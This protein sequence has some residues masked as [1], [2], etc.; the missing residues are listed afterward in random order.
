[1]RPARVAVGALLASLVPAC[2]GAPPRPPAAFVAPGF[3]S[4]QLATERL[5]VL[6]LGRLGLPEGGPRDL[7]RDSLEAALARLVEE[8]LATAVAETGVVGRTVGP[9]VI[10]PVLAGTA[11]A[12]RGRAY[13]ALDRATLTGV[14]ALDDAPADDLRSLGR[15]IGA[16]FLLVPHALDLAPADLFRFEA[17]LAVDLV[18]A[19]AGRVVWRETVRAES[20]GAPSGAAPD[21][22]VAALEGAVRAAA[23]RTATRLSRLGQDDAESAAVAP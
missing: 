10:A 1:M 22:Y 8:T 23:V 21:L 15:A 19:D 17:L 18:H 16:G 13:A 11:G 14:G 6:P 4:E 7:D 3:S 9:R 2:A 12:T 20:E 5:A